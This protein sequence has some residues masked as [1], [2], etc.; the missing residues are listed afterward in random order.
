M[1]NEFSTLRAANS[2]LATVRNPHVCVCRYRKCVCVLRKCVH[3]YNIYIY[4]YNILRQPKQFSGS[5]S[6]LTYIFYTYIGKYK[7]CTRTLP[8]P[9]PCKHFSSHSDPSIRKEVLSSSLVGTYQCKRIGNKNKNRNL[10]NDAATS[11]Q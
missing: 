1:L 6:I 5:F 4:T 10:L 3:S 7:L 11:L 8:R 2:T 9:P